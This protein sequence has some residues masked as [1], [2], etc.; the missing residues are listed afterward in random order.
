MDPSEPPSTQQQVIEPS[1]NTEVYEPFDESPERSD[2]DPGAR[3]GI[4]V[5]A[6]ELR[7]QVGKRPEAGN[8][9]KRSDR[10]QRHATCAVDAARE[11]KSECIEPLHTTVLLS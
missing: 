5:E 10:R 9:Q 7:K 4:A 8:P 6:V 11:S 2:H 3:N 1:E